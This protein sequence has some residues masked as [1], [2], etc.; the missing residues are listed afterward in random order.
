MQSWNSWWDADRS[1][2]PVLLIM[3]NTFP[4]PNFH[5]SLPADIVFYFKVDIHRKAKNLRMVK[6]IISNIS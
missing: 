1:E 3:I 5:L 6:R 2:R 4:F